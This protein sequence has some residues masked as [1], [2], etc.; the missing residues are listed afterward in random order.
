MKNTANIITSFRFIF[1]FLI[2]FV[3]PFST[4]FWLFYLCGGV[5]D[6]LDGFVAR[7]MHEQS[8]IGAKLDSIADVTFIIVLFI[9]AIKNITFPMWIYVS[10]I[11]IFFIRIISYI[12]GYFKYKCFSAVHTY[13]NKTS[14]MLLFISPVLY[15]IFGI[16]ITG[17]LI[18]LV[19][20]ISAVEELVITIKENKLNRD[21][22]GLL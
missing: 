2:L 1:A 18:C 22:R 11:I 17:I 7:K 9:V 20:F 19:T 4:V 5:S 3:Q 8:D 13:M 12:I 15:I 10:V 6:L 14:G 21:C 16:K